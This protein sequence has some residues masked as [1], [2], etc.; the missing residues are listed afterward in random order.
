MG[1]KTWIRKATPQDAEAMK[2]IA[3]R[4]IR[5]NYA[6]F[7]G[8]EAANA[9]IGSGMSDKEI[10]DNL[11]GS[12]LLLSGGDAIG[13]AI[14]KDDLLHLLMIDVPFQG[15]GF[16]GLLL[17]HA[18]KELFG[19][20]ATIRL[21]TFQENADAVRFYQR[22]GW[23]VTGEAFVKAIDQTMLFFEKTTI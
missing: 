18:E 12:T 21:Q 9:F 3:R 4:V 1:Q 6:P 16:G 14:A 20:Y 15:R 2:A 17:L 8:E 7:L 22:K 11:G 13:F 5:H 23:R 10:D 19:K